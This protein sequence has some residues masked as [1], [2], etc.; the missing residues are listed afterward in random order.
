MKSVTVGKVPYIGFRV[1]DAKS[2]LDPAKFS[3]K[4][5]YTQVDSAG[6]HPYEKIFDS[7]NT[8]IKKA[9]QFITFN[10]EEVGIQDGNKDI[11]IEIYYDGVKVCDMTYSIETY[12]GSMMNNEITGEL[13][14]S[15]LKLGASFRAYTDSIS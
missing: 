10:F 13:M 15:L 11:A 2:A 12:L 3:Y 7:T 14:T 5:A 6:E 8:S 1:K 9:G 4:V